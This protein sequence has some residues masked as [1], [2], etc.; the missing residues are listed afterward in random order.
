MPT[1]HF[2]GLR[3]GTELGRLVASLDLL[4]HPGADETFCQVVQEALCAG[5]PVVTVAAGGP[6]DLGRHGENGWLWAGDDPAVLAAQ[7]AAVRDDPAG[8]A[9]VTARTRPGV[10]GR[11]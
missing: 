1:A 2:L 5:V 10:V 11:T 7:V 6:L 4:V 3:T 9:E 8:R